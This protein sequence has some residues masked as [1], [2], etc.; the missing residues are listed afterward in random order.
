MQINLTIDR[1]NSATKIVVWEDNRAIWRETFPDF[2]ISDAEI[3]K[4]R[5]N[6]ARVMI[7][8][9]GESDARFR[10]NLTDVFGKEN[11]SLLSNTTPMPMVIDY[12]TPETLG[13]DRIAAAIG[14]MTIEPGSWL[15]IVDVGTAVTYDVVSDDGHFKGGNIAPGIGM[16][17]TALHE[18]TA[19]LPYVDS[20]GECPMFGY[21]T[22]T[23]MR[24]GAIRGVVAEIIYYHSKLP[25]G[26]KLILTGGWGNDLAKELPFK[27]IVKPCL[28]SIGLN[29]LISYNEKK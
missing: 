28:V 16:R 8:S 5:F 23:A 24:A 9:V 27:A 6:P 22:D 15:L 12:K 7:C 29:R 3:I 11:V 4:Q 10:K 18:F 17:L 20:P 14:G 21:S 25:E 2:A 26:T 13:T 1:G 19:R